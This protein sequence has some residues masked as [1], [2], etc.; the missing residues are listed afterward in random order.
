MTTGSTTKATLLYREFPEVPEDSLRTDLRVLA[1]KHGL[2][3]SGQSEIE[4]GKLRLACLPFEITVELRDAVLSASCFSG[5]IS[6]NLRSGQRAPL[7]KV[8][9]E[10]TAHINVAV[11]DTGESHGTREAIMPSAQ[12]GLQDYRRALIFAQDVVRMVM[13]HMEPEAVHWHPSNQLV[14]PGGLANLEFGRLHLPVCLRLRCA[15]AALSGTSVV[16]M[17]QDIVGATDFLGKPLHVMALSLNRFE[18]MQLAVAFLDRMLEGE[19]RPISGAVFRDQRGTRVEVVEIEPTEKFP[20]GLIALVELGQSTAPKQP[21]AASVKNSRDKVAS[22]VRARVK[23]RDLVRDPHPDTPK[24]PLSDEQLAVVK[25]GVEN[26]D[27]T[28]PPEDAAENLPT[29]DRLRELRERAAANA[30][31]G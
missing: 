22:R 19:A 26:S 27:F 2:P 16:N 8:V 18:T 31:S 24:Q 6:G 10:H 13:R 1:G 9:A 5:S 15:S 28:N 17:S 20:D 4:H 7:A 23:S 25:K 11:R 29:M 12:T 21:L 30:K 3:V 14:L